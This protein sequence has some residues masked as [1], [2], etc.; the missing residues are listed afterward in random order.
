MA[1]ERDYRFRAR[2]HRLGLSQ[3]ELGTFAGYAPGTSQVYV[4]QVER[5]CSPSPFRT[6]QIRKALILLESRSRRGRA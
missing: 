6:R 3:H 4:S 2:R 5:G 1:K